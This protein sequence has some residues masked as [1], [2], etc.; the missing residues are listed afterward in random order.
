MLSGVLHRC[1]PL[2]PE[3]AG[4]ILPMRRWQNAARLLREAPWLSACGA[5]APG[6]AERSRTGH[7]ATCNLGRRRLGVGPAKT[8]DA[9]NLARVLAILGISDASELV[10]VGLCRLWMTPGIGAN[11]I[12]A[13]QRALDGLGL[14]IAWTSPADLRRAAVIEMLLE[15]P[16]V[17][18]KMA[19]GRSWFQLYHTLDPDVRRRLR[20]LG[21]SDERLRG[22]PR[23]LALLASLPPCQIPDRM[24]A[25][26]TVLDGLQQVV[27]GITRLAMPSVLRG[28]PPGS[29]RIGRDGAAALLERADMEAEHLVAVMTAAELRSLATRLQQDR[30]RALLAALDAMESSRTSAVETPFPRNGGQ[31]EG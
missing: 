9:A 30:S 3:Q 13:C 1:T 19:A 6:L 25:W 14:P 10:R 4:S 2:D 31:P 15:L 7:G 23:A 5:G 21:L 17:A 22:L 20:T 24:W 8:D 28:V 29:V 18:A 27:I 26:H 12:A 16:D 11:R